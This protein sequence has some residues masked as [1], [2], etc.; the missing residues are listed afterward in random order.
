MEVAGT[1][2]DGSGFFDPGSDP[3]GPGYDNHITASVTGGVQVNHVTYVDPT[4][5]L[6]D[7][8]TR[9]A[10]TGAQD[11]T[12][13]NP[14]GQDATTTGLLTV[15][16]AGT[17][18]TTPCMTGTAPDS[19]AN[20]T[21]PKVLGAADPGSTVNLYTDSSCPAGQEVGTGT[22]S[23]FAFPGIAVSPPVQA[24]TTTMFYATATDSG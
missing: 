1:S 15:D 2:T 14:D 8:D 23:E 16:P 4:H 21:S 17:G 12:I 24:N 22:A 20:E 3:G 9:S 11:V 7:V 10:S 6:L 13:T 18:P 5:V 19:P